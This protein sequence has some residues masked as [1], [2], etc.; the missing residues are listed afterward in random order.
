MPRTAA[1]N[2]GIKRER[3][4]KAHLEEQGWVVIRTAGSLG[5]ADLVALK[6]ASTAARWSDGLLIEV[7]STAGPW[8]GFG[9][10]ARA[11]LRYAAR[12]AGV[13]PVLAWWPSRGQ[14]TWLYEDDWP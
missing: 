11:A 3:Q 5:C 1:Q 6:R 9:P 4:V 13:T 7:K 8:D 2:R 10:A 12:R 14:L